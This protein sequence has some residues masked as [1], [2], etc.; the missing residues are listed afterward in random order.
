[1]MCALLR[2]PIPSKKALLGEI[3]FIC[4]HSLAFSVRIHFNE[5]FVASFLNFYLLQGRL[6]ILGGPW[7]AS[8]ASQSP[9]FVS[10]CWSE[11]G[12]LI[13][14]YFMRLYC[15]KSISSVRIHH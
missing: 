3:R 7:A 1:M 15:I 6:A 9:G 11:N 5:F 8:I 13:S 12:I 14:S 4:K 2:R 10:W